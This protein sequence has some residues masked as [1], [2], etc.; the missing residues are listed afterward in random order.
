MSPRYALAF[1]AALVLAACATTTTTETA[2]MSPQASLEGV[3]WRLASARQAAPGA[4]PVGTA[5]LRFE[6]DRFSM[7]GPC[8]SHT[9]RWQRNGD[10]LVFGG[11]G[12]AIA[13]TR[14]MCPPPVMANAGTSARVI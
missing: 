12:G 2:P 4:A 3:D 6:A 13:S 7:R 1:G 14:M 8:N 10:Q 11:E 9:G 5:T